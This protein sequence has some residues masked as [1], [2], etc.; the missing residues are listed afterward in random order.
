MSQLQILILDYDEGIRNNL[1]EFFASK[2]YPVFPSERPSE[3]FAI[4]AQHD[5]DV[6]ILDLKL[7]EMDGIAVLKQ[8]KTD[9]PDIEVIMITGHSDTRSIVEAMRLG[10]FDFF[11][12]PFRML[13]VQAAI[14]RTDKFLALQQRLKEV[15]SNYS[16]ALQELQ[17][18]S[19]RPI[20][21]GSWAIKHVIELMSKVALADDTSVLIT[22]ES[23]TGKELVARGIHALSQRKQRYFYEMNCSAIPE[24]LFESELFG[25]KRGAFTG[26]AEERIGGIEAAHKGSLFLDE[27][28]DIPLSYQIKLLRVL[29]EK[30][31][32]RLGSNKEIPVDARIISATNQN[33]DHLVQENRFRLDLFHRINTFEIH[34][35]PLR[36]RQQDIPLLLEHFISYFSKK[37]RKPAL[38]IEHGA[39][40]VL[41]NYSFPGNVRELRNLTERAAILCDGDRLH[42]SHFCLPDGPS[43]PVDSSPHLADNTLNLDQLT[44]NAITAALQRTQ[45]NKSE[46]AKLLGISRYA[47]IRKLEKYL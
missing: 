16:F 32:K 27:I 46:A 29:E 24:N 31:I 41:Q 44:Q 38:T 34:L 20:I 8:I 30:T 6:A 35:S 25:H 23:G 2:T 4:L 40:Q 39:M 21:G 37:F 7:P 3:A 17:E 18:K 5:I 14:E 13:D 15:E 33:L 36:E 26:A 22:G 19:T 28:G 12:K 47:L 42:L 9:F 1:G 11:S 45:N 10:A 43:P